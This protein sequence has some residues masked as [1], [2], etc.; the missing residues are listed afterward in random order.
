M[1][2]FVTGNILDSNAQ[3][4]VNTVNCEGFM[5]KGI[6]YQFKLQFPQNNTSYIEACKTG[7]LKIGTIHYF[8]EKG[9]LIVNLPTKNKWREKSKIEYIDVGLS[10]LTKLIK[11][12][13]IKSIAIPPLGCGNGGLKW[14]EVKP[15][16]I[17]HLKPFEE[18]IKI[19][20]YEPTLSKI[21]TKSISSDYVPK[22]NASHLILMTFKPKLKRFNRLRLQKSAYFMNLF[23]GESYFKFDKY[24]FGP[25]AH[26]IDILIKEI[27]EFQKYYNVS[28]IKAI[29][30]AKKTLISESVQKK[31]DQYTSAI[32]KAVSF[33]N[34]INSDMEL[35]LFSTICFLLEKNPG[36]SQ[37]EIIKEIKDWSDDK[38]NKFPEDVILPAIDRL[39]KEN[40]IQANL[41]NTYNL[42]NHYQ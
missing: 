7:T 12:K 39:L 29:D 24:K 21:P 9:K 41:L 16:I 40:I 13:D 11:I 15:L 27:S 30:I 36:L 26:S 37:D 32:N 25:Y 2:T 38:A 5:G 6:A 10:E 1:L 35:E 17:K 31:I 28:T 18:T 22:I 42:K 4:L 33:V 34:S 23:S 14:T 20:I 19:F 3:C 8:H